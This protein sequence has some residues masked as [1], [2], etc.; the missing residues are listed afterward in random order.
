MLPFPLDSTATGVWAALEEEETTLPPPLPLPTPSPPSAT[1]QLLFKNRGLEPVPV[2]LPVSLA[3]DTCRLL[4]PP[5]TPLP[6][7]PPPPGTTPL[8]FVAE[9]TATPTTEPLRT[10]GDGLNAE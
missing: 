8:E 4:S 7:P 3:N 9:A 1:L 2:E 6:P 10:A 5:P